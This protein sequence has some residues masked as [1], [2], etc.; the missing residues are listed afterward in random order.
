ML[1]HNL[2]KIQY[3]FI[4]YLSILLSHLKSLNSLRV[5]MYMDVF[6]CIYMYT[7][8]TYFTFTVDVYII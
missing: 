3:Y 1:I 6:L 4:V 7:P 5:C 8:C 2:G